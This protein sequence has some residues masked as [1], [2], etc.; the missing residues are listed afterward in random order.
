M[1]LLAVKS[2]CI[3]T[4]FISLIFL[5]EKKL[6]ISM[7]DIFECNLFFVFTVDNFILTVD[8]LYIV[9][10]VSNF[11]RSLSMEVFRD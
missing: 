1:A 2:R 7:F 9:Y 11:F 8:D 6:N 4:L 10:Y 3:L 5:Q